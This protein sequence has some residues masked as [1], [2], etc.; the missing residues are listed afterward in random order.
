MM[1]PPV[2]AARPWSEPEG[3]TP[4]R[5]PLTT[6]HGGSTELGYIKFQAGPVAEY[7]V[8]GVQV[9]DVLEVVLRRLRGFQK[10]P[11]ACRENALAITRIEEGLAWLNVRTL[12]TNVPHAVE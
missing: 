1:Q 6:P 11:F 3:G 12:G 5:V 10:G 8:N 7:G 4:V 2:S 9:E